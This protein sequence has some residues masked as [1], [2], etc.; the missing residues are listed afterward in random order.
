VALPNIFTEKAVGIAFAAAFGLWSFYLHSLAGVV[1]E[2]VES[3][4][5]EQKMTQA[6]IVQLKA[7]IVQHQMWAAES[8][9][10]MNERQQQ[11]MEFMRDHQ[12]RHEADEGKAK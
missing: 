1:M 2:G 12:R 4:R 7:E 9:T 3:L 10:R 5:I 6:Q 11:F 8:G